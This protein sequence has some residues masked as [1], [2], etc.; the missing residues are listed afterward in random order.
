MQVS[1]TRKFAV[2]QI[3]FSRACEILLARMLTLPGPAPA[4]HLGMANRNDHHAPFH[5]H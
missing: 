4:T 2:N 5:I 3:L 1:A